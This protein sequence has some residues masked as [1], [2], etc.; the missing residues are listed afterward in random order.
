MKAKIYST[1]WCGWCD[2]AKSILKLAHVEYEEILLNN[3]LAIAQFRE[4]CPGLTS[5]PQIFIDGKLIGGYVELHKFLG[6]Y[7]EKDSTS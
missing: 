4:D 6:A 5:V 3:D 1:A 7:I 2:S